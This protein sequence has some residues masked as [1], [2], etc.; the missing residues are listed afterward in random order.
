MRAVLS[1]V[2]FVVFA[3]LSACASSGEDPTSFGPAATPATLAPRTATFALQ[4][5][6][7]KVTWLSGRRASRS[8]AEGDV[9]FRVEDANGR[10]IAER[11]T[12]DDLG[13]I[14]PVLR[15]AF[16]SATAGAGGQGT[17]LDARGTP[18]AV[19]DREGRHPA[20]PQLQGILGD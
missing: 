12:L 18:K 9:R 6:D 14:D 2:P 20:Q 10:L 15:D 4:T 8:S 19:G 3:A 13:T 16:E 5:R 17:Y 7:H 11:A 1:L